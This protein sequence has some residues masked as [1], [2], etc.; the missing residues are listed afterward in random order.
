MAKKHAHK[1]YYGLRVANQ[2]VWACALPGCGHYM[3]HH[4]RDAVNNKAAIC[5]NCEG[6]AVVDLDLFRQGRY[7]Q[8][9]VWCQNCIDEREALHTL[10]ARTKPVTISELV[11]TSIETVIKSNHESNQ[12][13]VTTQ[14]S[15][16]VICIK[17]GKSKQLNGTGGLCYMCFIYKD[18]VR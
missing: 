6:Y 9:K 16:K 3:P 4:M 14:E 13:S 11:G 5:W 8:N 2:T 12:E 1:Y 17:C 18:G 10:E 7:P 15:E